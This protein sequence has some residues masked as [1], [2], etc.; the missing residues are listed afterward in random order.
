[1]FVLCD[2]SLRWY[3]IYARKL[4]FFNTAG[5]FA[6]LVLKRQTKQILYD[7]LTGFHWEI[8]VY[9]G[10]RVRKCCENSGSLVF[11]EL[12]MQNDFLSSMTGDSHQVILPQE[13]IKI[14]I[15]LFFSRFSVLLA[16]EQ[17]ILFRHWS[18]VATESREKAH[19]PGKIS[20]VR[21]FGK[22]RRLS[23]CSL[24]VER[25]P[26][27]SLYGCRK[28]QWKGPPFTGRRR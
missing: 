14:L 22:V 17:A 10:E 12:T 26:R 23:F 3:S 11:S 27:K 24:S 1:M 5:A 13:M 4:S 19:E 9:K 18:L 16:Y 2:L 8:L 21:S 6:S 7:L 15:L 28:Y 25:T 20:C